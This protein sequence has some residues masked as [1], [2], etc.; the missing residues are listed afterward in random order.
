MPLTLSKSS[1]PKQSFISRIFA[2]SSSSSSRPRKTSSSVAKKSKSSKSSP[3]M[4]RFRRT[5]PS[6][7]DKLQAKLDPSPNA[8]PESIAKRKAKKAKAK[9]ASHK[10]R[11]SLFGRN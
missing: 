7:M 10:N 6:T 3:L 1:P 4:S 8:T 2:G 5:P 9:K 11:S